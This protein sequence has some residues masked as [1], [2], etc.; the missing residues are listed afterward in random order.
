MYYSDSKIENLHR[1]FMEDNRKNYLRLD[2]NENPGGLSEDFI[3][4]VLREVSPQTLSEYPEMGEFTD[5]LAAYLGTDRDHLCL[6]NGSSEGIRYIIQVFSAPGGRI[7]GVTPSYA[8]FEV[9]AEMYGREFFPVPYTENLEMPIER[10]LE[11]MTADTQL[12][13]LVNP[14]NPM[15]NAYSREEFL[16]I[17]DQA[18]QNDI[19][20]LVDE[21]YFYFYPE[22]FIDYALNRKHIFITRT[23]S[24]LFSLAGARL[25]YVVGWPEGIALLQKMC[26]P[27]NV[28][29][30][31]ELFAQ[32]IIETPGMIEA[33]I[34]KHREGRDY[35]E[36]ALTK[37]GY[38][39]QGKNGNFIFIRQN[40]DADILVQKMKD[41]KGILIKSYQ[42]IG[43][44]GTCLRVSTAEK[45]YME[46]FMQA[47]L[48]LDK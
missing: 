20:I 43:K 33:L 31:A 29:I 12:L 5:T 4:E 15:G 9:Y 32:K 18:E 7:V 10:V 1:V 37:A 25:G 26:T 22:T 8:M 6:V 27:H 30:F 42:G 19:T 17:L 48:E 16:Q 46:R 47:L 11:A 35:L 13:I 28:N 45:Q 2:L 39:Y 24:K 34:Q 41:E 38:S 3:K 44:F 40:T 36:D 21:A 14:N 23:F